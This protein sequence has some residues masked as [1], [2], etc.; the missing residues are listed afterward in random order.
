MI[1]SKKRSISQIVLAVLIILIF[2]MP[3]SAEFSLGDSN[4]QY[5]S[6][7]PLSELNLSIDDSRKDIEYIQYVGVII[8]Q[9]EFVAVKSTSNGTT[10]VVVPQDI[11]TILNVPSSSEVSIPS[12]LIRNANVAQETGIV[13]LWAPMALLDYSVKN[14]TA[15]ISAKNSLYME[16]SSLENALSVSKIEYVSNMDLQAAASKLSSDLQTRSS[17]T[18]YQERSL[19]DT[20]K[21]QYQLTGMTGTLGKFTYSNSGNEGYTI[22][23]E[24][25]IYLENYDCIEFIC[26][27]NNAELNNIQEYFVIA[28]DNQDSGRLLVSVTNGNV[29]YMEYYC[30]IENTGYYVHLK[31]PITGTWYN[32][33][34]ADPTRSSRID[35]IQLSSEYYMASLYPTLYVANTIVEDW[36]RT[37]DNNWYAPQTTM[38]HKT[39]EDT[40]DIYVSVN[41]SWTSDNK[42]SSLHASGTTVS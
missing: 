30:Y 33:N 35:Y 42:L 18:L 14:N 1:V 15:I 36:T 26:G 38:F 20:Y 10:T 3:V 23:H 2:I 34:Y 39:S 22:Y 12:Q 11:I 25:E 28:I 40:R 27:L 9:T 4:N 31:D 29:P 16:F 19:Y 5:W 7:P 24:N 37:R 17:T 32:G 6:A 21:T 13:I 8:P 41:P